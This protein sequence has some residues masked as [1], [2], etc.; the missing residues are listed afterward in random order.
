[1]NC[2]VLLVLFDDDLDKRICDDHIDIIVNFSHSRWFHLARSLPGYTES[3]IKDIVSGISQ[4]TGEVRN[5]DR[6]R[7]VLKTWI[8]RDGRFATLR[9]ALDA[10][11]KAQ[12]IGA[13]VTALENSM[14]MN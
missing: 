5:S 13:V 10:C 3:D 11:Q 1:M 7:H 2:I 4:Y 14:K 6:L 9:K 12:T 8:S